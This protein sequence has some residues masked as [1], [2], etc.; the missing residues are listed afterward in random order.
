ME[1]ELSQLLKVRRDKLKEL[2]DCGRD[3]FKITKF[4]GQIRAGEI[5]DNYKAYD[6][7]TVTVAGRVMSKRR[8]GKIGFAHL[9]DLTGQ[10]Q[11]VVKKI[12]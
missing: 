6:G 2:Q 9:Q 10:I 3:P 12:L 11:L 7:K 5:K 1:N 4:D 8:M